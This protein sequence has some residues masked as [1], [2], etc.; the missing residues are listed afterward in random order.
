MARDSRIVG[1]DMSEYIAYCIYD[2]LCLQL[3]D[4]L[5]KLFI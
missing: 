1:F 4:E 5:H 3:A 2:C